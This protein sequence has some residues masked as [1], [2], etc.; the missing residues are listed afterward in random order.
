MYK[1]TQ[2]YPCAAI[3]IVNWNGEK[4]LKHCLSS[5]KAADY[6]KKKLKVVVVDNGSNDNSVFW[7]VKLFSAATIIKNRQN[8][9]FAKANN[10]GIIR[11]LKDKNVKYIVTL[12]NDTEID[13]DWLKNLVSFMEKNN[14]VGVAVG[15]ILQF[16]NRNKIDSAGDFIS[17]DTLRIINR[18]YNEYDRG[19]YDSPI[20]IFSACAAASIFRRQTLE[21]I[22]ID[23]EFFDESFVSYIED[24]DLNIRAKLKGWLI[25]Y[26]PDAIVYHIGSAT[27][28]R[29]SKAYKEY[30]SRRNR[31]LMAVKNL[32]FKFMI[33]FIL[34]YIVPSKYGINF[35]MQKAINS[36]LKKGATHYFRKGLLFYT[37]L[38]MERFIRGSENLA[39]L[40]VFFVH[41]KAIL[42]VLKLLPDTLKKRIKIQE[43]KKVSNDE[44]EEWFRN[45]SISQ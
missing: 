31:I 14:K 36:R 13:K 27:S 8:Y 42:G 3:V 17:R 33:F 2:K 44:I 32:P 6:P 7:A 10:I 20:E 16:N 18:G 35:H 37:K 26:V 1:N 22:Q 24:V 30:F 28:S 25:F 34:R 19:Q 4:Y 11:A 12:N 40:E 41:T 21:E 9:G 39:L 29:L 5:L 45:F 43:N 15:K 23:K 38:G